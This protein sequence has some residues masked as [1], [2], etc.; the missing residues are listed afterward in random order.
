MTTWQQEAVGIGP[1]PYCRLAWVGPGRVPTGVTLVWGVAY[2]HPSDMKNIVVDLS[3]PDTLAAFD[4][5][6]AL[7][8]GAPEEAVREG[9]L[10]WLNE[11]EPLNEDGWLWEVQA[12]GEQR[13]RLSGGGYS[14]TPKWD[15]D[16]IRISTRDPLLARVRA[17]KFANPA[18]AG[19]KP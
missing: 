19:G 7:R 10:F 1:W 6:L 8:L 5:R 14:S 17:W 18:S 9:A 15:G 13:E 2:I 11:A 4:R 3:D 16:C 12:G